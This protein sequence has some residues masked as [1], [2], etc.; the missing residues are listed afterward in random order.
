MHSINDQLSI[1]PVYNSKPGSACKALNKP[2]SAVHSTDRMSSADCQKVSGC[3]PTL[4]LL[5]VTTM[6]QLQASNE[7]G[8]E[9]ESAQI[10]RGKEG[11]LVQ[12]SR[13]TL[14]KH[15]KLSMAAQ[16]LL[17]FHSERDRTQSTNS[18]G[19]SI[20]SSCN[21]IL[22]NQGSHDL[23]KADVRNRKESYESEC[24]TTESFGVTT[25]T[26]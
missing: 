10:G 1:Q 23:T 13:R 3:R 21:E 22:S 8:T 18:S 9:V 6:S 7:I 4:Q 5:Q 25:H 19:S 24:S 2:M 14:V 20:G 15:P 12:D 16:A 26:F 17:N 11:V